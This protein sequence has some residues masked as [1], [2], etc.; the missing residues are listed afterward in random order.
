MMRILSVLLLILLSTGTQATCVILLH[1]LFR[2]PSSLIKLEKALIE[3]GFATVNRGYP[4]RKHPIEVLADLAIEPALKACPEG[5][6]VSFVTHSL[7][8][9]LVRQYLTHHAMPQL[10]RVVMLGPP[11]KGSELADSLGNV[12]GL[13]WIHGPAGLQLGTGHSSV[14]NQL[15]RVD[16]DLG[17]I[18]GDRSINWILSLIIPGEDDGK[19][20]IDNTKVEGMNEHIVLPVNHAMMMNNPEVIEAVIAYLKEGKWEY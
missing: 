2:T 12:D 17:I 20:S 5:E 18:A 6:G 15:G 3:E 19:V 8:G 11:N 16:F 4:S 9:I 7:G 1:G 13:E 14:P 10:E